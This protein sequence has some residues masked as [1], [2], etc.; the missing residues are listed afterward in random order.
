LARRGLEWNQDN[1]YNVILTGDIPINAGAASS[2]AFVTAWGFFLSK[3]AGMNFNVNEIAELGFQSEVREFSESG[4]MMDHFSSAVGG[5]FYMQQSPSLVLR[6]Y[7]KCEK[8]FAHS[9]ILIDSEQKKSTVEDLHRIKKMT[10]KSYSEMSKIL[11]NFDKYTTTI[12]EIDPFINKINLKLGKMLLGSL[13]TRDI[14]RKASRIL[15]KGETQKFTDVDKKKI[16]DLFQKHHE[17]LSNNLGCSTKKIDA[18]LKYCLENGAYGGKINGSGFGGT[19]FVFIPKD[20]DLL[21]KKL[22]QKGVKAYPVEIS[23]GVQEY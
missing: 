21:L 23:A 4:G 14:T 10:F 1:G 2:S 13:I 12:S 18:I 9:F 17:N 7:P 19:L 11:K 8:N 20:R 15:E 6:K 22:V 16:G 5:I 3:I